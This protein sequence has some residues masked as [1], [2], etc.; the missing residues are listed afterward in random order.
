MRLLRTPANT[1]AFNLAL[2]EALLRSGTPTLRLYSWS[3]PGYSLGFFQKRDEHDVPEGFACVRRPTGGGAIAHVGEL[4]I[5]WVGAKRRVDEVYAAINDTV[6]RALRT[7]SLEAGRGVDAPEA[8][9]QGLCFDAHTCYDLLVDG[10]KIFGSAQ[11]R[12]RDTFLLH[13]S[14]VLERNPL[15]AG[16]ISLEELVGPVALAD[17]EEAIIHAWDGPLESGVLTPDEERAVQDLI[18][19]RYGNEAWTSRR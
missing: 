17:A 7:W 5:S 9:P 4:T 13:G 16:A 12:A 11:R 10:R 3:P 8:A 14:L 6:T 18:E 1:P 15:S 19:T 2:D